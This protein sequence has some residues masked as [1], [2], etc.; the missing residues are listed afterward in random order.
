LPSW[1]SDW[2]SVLFVWLIS[3]QSAVLF[4]QNKPATNNQPKVI[5]FSEQISTSHQPPAKRTG[6]SSLAS[7]RNLFISRK[8][9]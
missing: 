8:L 2:N 9:T 1:D 5:F 3:H 4:S 6:C 7:I